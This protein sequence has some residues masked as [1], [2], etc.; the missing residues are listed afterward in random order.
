MTNFSSEYPVFSIQSSVVEVLAADKKRK[1]WSSLGLREEISLWVLSE[2]IL[3][4][5]KFPG[6]I[7]DEMV[8]IVFVYQ[9]QGSCFY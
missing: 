1:A 3:D 6:V 8:Y 4:Q 7:I 9:A 2:E 5:A